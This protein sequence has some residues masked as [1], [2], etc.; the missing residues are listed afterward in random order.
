MASG[1]SLPVDCCSLCSNGSHSPRRKPLPLLSGWLVCTLN[2]LP[3]K[4][5]TDTD[6]QYFIPF[7]YAIYDYLTDQRMR[8]SKT[9]NIDIDTTVF[10]SVKHTLLQ[11]GI[12]Y[13]F[14]ALALGLSSLASATF[15]SVPRSSYI[16]A[17]SSPESSFILAMN[18]L[19][20]ALDSAILMAISRLLSQDPRR[21]AVWTSAAFLVSLRLAP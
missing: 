4:T 11:T 20:F 16:C 19:A 15:S 3:P 9:E 13:I 18:L 5:S 6:G 17:S 7:A 8:P 2:H 12:R 14:I 21:G 1:N 10:D